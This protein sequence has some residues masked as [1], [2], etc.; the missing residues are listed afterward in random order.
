MVK[1]IVRSVQDKT[2][3]KWRKLESNTFKYDSE[4]CNNVHNHFKFVNFTD[5]AKRKS[6][7]KL[8]EASQ[9][10]CQTRANVIIKRDL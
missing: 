10:S 1:Y 6:K 7:I 8:M 3:K 4:G 5:R 2:I 9:N